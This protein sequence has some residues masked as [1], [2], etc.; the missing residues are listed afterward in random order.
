MSKVNK[1]LLLLLYL[2][3]I[4]LHSNITLL[5]VPRNLFNQQA[6]K[7]TYYAH[8]QSHIQYGIAIWGSMCSK[9]QLNKIQHIQDECLKYIYKAKTPLPTNKQNT[10]QKIEN[11]VRL[12]IMKL[13]I[14]FT[15]MIYPRNLFSS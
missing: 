2:R 10:I 8:M 13:D 12:E 5:R 4:I 9:T 1:L 7:K 15:I 14:D 11:L 6:L 3:D